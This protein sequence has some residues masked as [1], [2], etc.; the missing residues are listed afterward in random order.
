MFGVIQ[1]SDALRSTVFPQGRVRVLSIVAPVAGGLWW[2]LPW[3][4][5]TLSNE[6]TPCS[7]ETD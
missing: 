3:V 6:E 4:S 1:C 2:F 5:A 7:S